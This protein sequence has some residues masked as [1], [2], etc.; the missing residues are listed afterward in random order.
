MFELNEEPAIGPVDKAA[1]SEQDSIAF[2]IIHRY[3]DAGSPLL[4][5]GK[6]LTEIPEQYR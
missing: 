1:G 4:V 5:D 2:G 3:E 6:P